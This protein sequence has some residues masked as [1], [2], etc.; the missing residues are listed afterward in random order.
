[1]NK[2]RLLLGF[3]LLVGAA[4]WAW[5]WSALADAPVAVELLTLF[6]VLAIV[7]EGLSFR[8][9][10]DDPHSLV[11]VVNLAA[12]LVLG[13]ASGAL[14]AG[15]VGFAMGVVVPLAYGRPRTLY[16]LLGKPA[17]RSGLRIIGILTGAA[18][19]GQL[20]STPGFWLLLLC[21]VP[22]YTLVVALG[23]AARE[24]LAGGRTGL[25]TWWRG[26]WRASLLNE[27]L[28]LPLAA[29]LAVALLRLD[30]P[31]F[32]LACASLIL[33]SLALRQSSLAVQQQRVSVRELSLLNASS[34]A[35]LRSE[36]NV[37]QLCDVIY[38]EASTIVDTSSFHLGLF[39]GDSYTLVVQVID[40]VRKPPLTV[41]V[42][43]GDGIVGWM[44]RT[45]R[46]LLVHDFLDESERLP[47]QPSYQSAHPPRSGIY[48]PLV[49]GDEVIGSISIQSYQ[50]NAF[51]ADNLR[52]LSLIAD[53]S[54]VALARA[55]AYHQA[56]ERA[57]QL[58]AIRE[59]SERVTAL[60][61]LDE[62]LPEV[63][64][65]V[66]ERFGYHPV[67]IFTADPETKEMVFRASSVPTTKLQLLRIPAGRGV[68]GSVAASGESVL[69]PD[70]RQEPRYL[71]DERATRSELVVPLK[72]GET[73]LGV[74]DVQSDEVDDFD[75]GDL[76]VIRTL[77]DQVA[78]AIEGANLYSQE[79]EEAWTLNGL[80]QV[81][82]HIA[83]RSDFDGLVATLVRLPSLLV[84]CRRTVLL[85]WQEDTRTFVALASYG[86][87]PQ[88]REL[89]HQPI[90]E[91][92]A[93]LLATMRQAGKLVVLADSWEQP[94]ALP[95]LTTALHAR[96]LLV[97]PLLAR[98]NLLG[99]LVVDY[100]E[101][102]HHFSRRQI[103]SYGGFANQ[104][105]AAIESALLAQ[106]AAAA[107]RLEQEL[108][109][110][111]DI[112]TTLL[113]AAPPVLPGYQ[114]AATWRAAKIV[115]GDFY[116]F[117]WLP[118]GSERGQ[119]QG[120]LGFVIADVSDKGVPAA[121][122]MAL[123]RSLVRAAALDGSEPF[124]ALIRAN[125]WITRDSESG[126]FVTL[127][128]GVLDGTTGLLRYT[129]AGHNPPLHYQAA[130]GTFTPLRTPG[131]ALG[132]LEEI[133]LGQATA[134]LHPGD[135]L[136][137]YTDGVTEAING[138][139][140]PF[141]VEQLEATVV[142]ARSHGADGVVQAIVAALDQW[143]GELPAFDDVTL[144][145]I[146]RSATP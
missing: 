30:W 144:L 32:A 16:S 79:Q 51:S 113:P 134:V 14:V 146:E 45:R 100:H 59:V 52:L 120:E 145:V 31:F 136:V 85:R 41:D 66:H 84:G 28:P 122:Y 98:G 20:S 137:C 22:C 138:D 48:I 89:L 77:A 23:R 95:P 5:L 133:S 106:E 29:L 64:R 121:L 2:E 91:P 21:I 96:S 37:E 19:A 111:R 74:L 128:Y 127:F 116:D 114:V 131:I 27:V 46:S 92:D 108:R 142:A 44:R 3:C 67:H 15:T 55:Q 90:A 25:R 117:W 71:R 141:E 68:V 119:R 24:Y 54:A 115:G 33:V 110:A 35:L 129:C 123:S 18:L 7:V 53:Q 9:P 93:P 58:Q 140:E 56:R 81:N 50:P 135:M 63:V 80:L 125:R 107:S 69:V 49:A 76:F 104:A 112:Q 78:I 40:R 4:G 42:A 6:M 12:V 83:H 34:R 94:A 87:G 13:P 57:N 82:E 97:A 103:G 10:P 47:A 86:F 139:E 130:S 132:V 43:S 11:G 8:L 99:A 36:L 124:Q 105:A 143:C 38:R 109:V 73:V 65:L 17:L 72:V 70:V 39:Q 75:E 102:L 88:G 61:N 60:L 62:L 118:Q 26:S 126:M 101:Q 1:M